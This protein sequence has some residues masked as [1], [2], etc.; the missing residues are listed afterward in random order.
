MIDIYDLYKPGAY[1]MVVKPGCRSIIREVDIDAAGVRAAMKLAADAMAD[2]M[3]KAT[4]L[5]PSKQTTPITLEQRAL[6]DQLR[7]TGF[8]TSTWTRASLMEVIDAGLREL[9]AIMD[10]PQ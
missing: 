1:L 8:N 10:S 7:A 4:E 6:L 5:Q 2:C 9:K 3:S